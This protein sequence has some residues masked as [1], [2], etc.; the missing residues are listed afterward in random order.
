MD[1]RQKLNCDPNHVS[2]MLV[3]YGGHLDKNISNNYL[4]SAYVVERS[5]S[6][7][8]SLIDLDLGYDHTDARSGDNRFSA[9]A[10]HSLS[11][12]SNLNDNNNKSLCRFSQGLR[13]AISA[14]LVSFGVTILIIG[15]LVYHLKDVDIGSSSLSSSVNSTNSFEVYVLENDENWFGGDRRYNISIGSMFMACG[16][17]AIILGISLLLTP[18]IKRTKS[19]QTIPEFT[20]KKLSSVVFFNRKDIEAIRKNFERRN[21]VKRVDEEATISHF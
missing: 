6:R 17:L 2:K 21:S 20:R 10:R 4:P 13:I 16:G 1:N 3:K 5:N 11:G 19:V 12:L 8:S 9:S 15:I 18:L 14:A 7:R